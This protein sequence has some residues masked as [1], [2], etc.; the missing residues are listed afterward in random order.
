MAD[1]NQS[2]DPL[3]V[4][5]WAFA[6]LERFGL[7]MMLVLALSYGGYSG[8]AWLGENVAKPLVAGHVHFMAVTE[9]I[10]RKQADNL[11]RV[12][13]TQETLSRQQAEL[14]ENNKEIVKALEALAKKIE[15]P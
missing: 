14:A 6:A 4:K 8:L 5:H 7:P 12:L 15:K 9:E 1:T 13:A 11:E 3:G 10:G 2:T